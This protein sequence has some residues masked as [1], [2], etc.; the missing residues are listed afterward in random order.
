[1][2][3]ELHVGTALFPGKT[4]IDQLVNFTQ[5]LGPLPDEMVSRSPKKDRFY[6]ATDGSLKTTRTVNHD[7]LANIIGV[8]VGGPRGCRKGQDGHDEETYGHFLDFVER[9]LRYDPND[10]MSCDEA[11]QHPFLAPLLVLEQQH[12]QMIRER[13]AAAASGEAPA[14][15]PTSTTGGPPKPTPKSSSA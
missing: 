13:E 6:S 1:M 5:L 15:V 4:E 14:P 10:R 11:F 3:V 12:L 8:K 9:L 2:L 7:R